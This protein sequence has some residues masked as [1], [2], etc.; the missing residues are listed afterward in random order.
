MRYVISWRVLLPVILFAN[1][2]GLLVVGL[3]MLGLNA[4]F[5]SH[6][7]TAE[8]VVVAFTEYPGAPRNG[9]PAN[10]TFAPV[11]AFR[12]AD[13]R[14][15]RFRS[16]HASSRLAYAAGDRVGV[17]YAPADPERAMIDTFRDAWLVPLVLMGVGSLLLAAGTGIR[18]I[19]KW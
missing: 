8:G 7:A 12:S 11:I 10:S 17:L 1:G 13:G 4:H 16:P 6:A 19:A 14:D 18:A 9:V 15:I 5:V 3:A 2:A